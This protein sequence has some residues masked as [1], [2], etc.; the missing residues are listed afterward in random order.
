MKIYIFSL[1]LMFLSIS[2]KA[3]KNSS[4]GQLRKL[5][6]SSKDDTKKTDLLLNLGDYYLTKRGEFKN[7]LDSASFFNQ[8]A[9]LLSSKNGNKLGKGKSMLLDAKID[10]EKGLRNLAFSK[11]KQAIHYFETNK[12]TEQVAEGY[13]ELSFMY[14]NG[15]KNLEIKIKLKEKALSLFKSSGTTL[16]Q[17]SVLKDLGEIYGIKG[18]PDKSIELLKQS[19]A[20]YNSLKFKELQGVY[21]LLIQAE[22]QKANYEEALKYCILAEK[23]AINVH[24]NSLQLSSIYSNTGMVYYYLR[25]ND[26]AMKYWEKALTIA[27]KNNDNGY[28]RTVANNMSTMLIRQRKFE[29]AIKMIKEYKTRYPIADQEFEMTENYILFSTYTIL[30]QLKN[31]EIYYK[32]LVSYYGENAEKNNKQIALLRGFV[33]YRYQTKDYAAFYKSAA[34]FD[35]VA[36][37]SGNDM[38]RSENY[39]IWFKADSTQGK[40]LD[41]IEHYQLY[42]KLSDSVFN[43]EK[44]KQ[45]NSL[46]IQFE[47]DQKDKNIQLLTQKGKLLEIQVTNDTVIKYVFI[48]SILVLILFA[49]LLYNR[50]R[51]KS[52]ANKKLEL[53]RKQIDEQ[54]EQLKKLLSEKEWLLKEIHHR[55]KNNLQIVISL[56]NTQSAYLDNEDALM[57]IQNSQHRMHAMSLIHQKLYQ[58]DNLST[59]D[60]S[61]YIYELIGYIK[62]CYS[63]E[64]SIRFV[65]DT[66]KV[67]LDVA[68]A[69]PMGLIVNEAVNNIVKY[70]FPDEEKGEVMVSFKNTE[71]D[72]YELIISDNGV[73]LPED[74]NI[75]ETESLG[76]NLM[77]GLTD[78]LDGTFSLENKNGLKI[79]ITFRKNTDI[80]VHK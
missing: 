68:Q 70:A 63:S 35:S 39:L 51:L 36:K 61:W 62:E 3:Q 38:L 73:G 7:D 22:V 15:T 28:V 40:Y 19:L 8:Q 59:I 5:I 64:K 20:V 13:E 47:T 31:A 44:S 50:S 54:N 49:A 41:A 78:Q 32:K 45:I 25:Q 17:A 65:L 2:V 80:D 75:D 6:F 4:P 21:N 14:D 71:K 43:G 74:F 60:M 37:K 23:T 11:M 10:K 77:R 33:F 53:K 58:S 9:M 26:D 16:K 66:E 12:M 27:K 55:V 18:D 29:E 57:A 69:V 67:F 24:D 76:M 30:K 72:F 42:K 56:L 79:I 1:V 52:N 46:K 48:G 34:L